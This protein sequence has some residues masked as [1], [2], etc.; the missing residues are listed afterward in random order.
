MCS[1]KRLK[2][3]FL[4]PFLL[5][6]SEMQASRKCFKVLSMLYLTPSM[7]TISLSATYGASRSISGGSAL[8][9]AGT[10][11]STGTST[12]APCPSTG[13]SRYIG[14]EGARASIARGALWPSGMLKPSTSGGTAK[15][16]AS[17]IT[18]KTD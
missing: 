15:T 4:D 17:V 6:P 12:T 1:N 8:S 2:Q 13:L 18:S 14:R 7:T 3:F 11:I 10:S 5:K 9:A 16:C